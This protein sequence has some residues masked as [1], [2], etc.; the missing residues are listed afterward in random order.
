VI[1]P[2]YVNCH[3]HRQHREPKPLIGSDQKARGR[4]LHPE[5]GAHELTCCRCAGR[6]YIIRVIQ[7]EQGK[8]AV[9]PP[10]GQVLLRGMLLR[11]RVPDEKPK[12]VLPRDEKRS[13]G[14]IRG[15][16]ANVT[17]CCLLSVRALLGGRGD[18]N[19]F[20]GFLSGRSSFGLLGLAALLG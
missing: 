12:G 9:S 3:R 6:D 1:C 17:L 19:G 4:L 16:N 13:P 7:T 18:G 10:T 15:Q 2:T 20:L 11:Q 14:R 5:L 8:P